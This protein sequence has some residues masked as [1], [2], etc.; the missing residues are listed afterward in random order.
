M[1][2]NNEE[3]GRFPKTSRKYV[4]V[5]LRIKG[6]LAGKDVTIS[7][8][9]SEHDNYVS[10][11]CANQLLIPKSNIIEEID[12][13]NEKKYSISK[14]QLNMGE[15]IFVSQ[16]VVK[17]MWKDDGDIIL[18]SSWMEALGTFILNMKNKFLTFSYKNKKITLQDV[19]LEPDSVTQEDL[20]DISKVILQ[21]NQKSMQ[22]MQKEIDKIITDKNE[23][24]SRGTNTNPINVTTQEDANPVE[25]KTY[26]DVGIQTMGTPSVLTNQNSTI[27]KA[28]SIREENHISKLNQENATSMIRENHVIRT[29]YRRPNH[30]SN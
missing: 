17:S 5:L 27:N 26:R 11:E 18:G 3:K 9:P 28:T 14:L 29:P 19:T 22:N 1:E 21:E 12:L 4:S 13:W 20:K 25:E 15:Y 8:D 24:I 6:T 30:K 16:F 2:S 7:I 23:E 10:T